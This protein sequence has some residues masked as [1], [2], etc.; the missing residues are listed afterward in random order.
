M[1]TRI[2]SNILDIPAHMP[3]HDRAMYCLHKFTVMMPEKPTE[4]TKM[5]VDEASNIFLLVLVH[6]A[7]HYDL[8][9]Y[10]PIN[11]YEALHQLP[12]TVCSL[13]EKLALH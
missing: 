7:S 13:Y 8:H 12:G 5:D 9:L 1:L 4:A 6:M 3:G 11:I 10:L 2:D